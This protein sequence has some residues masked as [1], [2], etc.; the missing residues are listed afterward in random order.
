MRMSPK[1]LVAV[2]SL[3]DGRWRKMKRRKTEVADRQGRLCRGR[4][5]RQFRRPGRN[6]GWCSRR[7]RVRGGKGNSTRISGERAGG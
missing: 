1:I 4:V 3:M 5:E 6:R 7:K 2:R